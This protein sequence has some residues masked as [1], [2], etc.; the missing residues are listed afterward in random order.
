MRA[1]DAGCEM[2][3]TRGHTRE[4]TE[5]SVDVQP[6]AVPL[7]EVRHALERIEVAGVHLAGVA[8]DDRRRAIQRPQRILE[9]SEIDATDIVTREAP[10]RITADPEH[11]E[12]FRRA[13]MDVAARE[14]RNGRQTRE[15]ARID[16]DAVTLRPPASRR[17]KRGEVRHRRARREH[18]APRRGE[19]EQLLQ[20]VDRDLFAARAEWRRV[21][22]GRVLIEGRCEPV[23]GESCWRRPTD[24]PVE[25]PRPRGTER[26]VRRAHQLVD[27]DQRAVAVL[28]ECRAERHRGGVS[29]GAPD[30][31][32]VD[33]REIA[34]RRGGRRAQGRHDVSALEDRVGHALSLFS[35]RSDKCV[36]TRTTRSGEAIAHDGAPGP[37]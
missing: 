15:P 36:S 2:R 12:R 16:V 20:P 4:E 11:R 17:R 22:R 23:R 10:D 32:R 14:H 1:L 33:R 34:L 29:T 21:V 31:I 37:R 35:G 5:G 8:H 26:P 27:R 25:E 18:A 19:S 28:R 30:E 7:R 6:R 13:R 24:D 9:R 3:G